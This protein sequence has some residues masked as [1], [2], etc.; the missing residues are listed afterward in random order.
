VAV[1]GEGSL[2]GGTPATHTSSIR[3]LPACPPTPSLLPRPPAAAHRPARP[4]LLR[5]A[6]RAAA[7]GAHAGDQIQPVQRRA[8]AGAHAALE[9][10]RAARARRRGPQRRAA[11]SVRAAATIHSTAAAAG[12]GA[13]ER[14]VRGEAVAEAVDMELRA[15]AGAAHHVP[16]D[17]ALAQRA[18]RAGRAPAAAAAAAAAGL[19]PLGGALLAAPRAPRR[20]RRRCV[21]AAATAAAGAAT[22]SWRLGGRRPRGGVPCQI[23]HV[24]GVIV[25]APAAAAD[26]VPRQVPRRAGALAV[27]ARLGPVLAAALA[28][29]RRRLHL[30]RATARAFLAAACLGPRAAVVLVLGAERERPRQR[31]H[32]CHDRGQR[33][34]LRAAGWG[35]AERKQGGARRV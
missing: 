33:E 34:R 28:P 15:A 17:R 32:G 10:W 18:A 25:G 12:A 24:L 29:R 22:G 5:C 2:Q 6:A 31:V 9:P 35:C 7:V 3:A 1:R 16:L 21:L 27:N 14:A 19:V 11:G 20:R 4:Q 13:G 30:G 26:S 8:A 23:V